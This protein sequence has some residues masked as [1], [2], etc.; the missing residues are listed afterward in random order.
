MDEAALLSILTEHQVLTALHT[1]ESVTV[2][3][4]VVDGLR[5][6][7]EQGELENAVRDYIA[8]NPWL[9]DPK[10]DTYKVERAMKK[11]VDPEATK[12]F[13]SEMLD[14]RLD[15][16]LASGPQLLVLEFMKP[17]LKL[18]G[19]HLSRFE[20]YV[21]GLRNSVESATGS[22]FRQVAG[23]IVADRIEEDPA[24]TAKLRD[25]AGDQKFALTWQLL[26]ERS[27]KHWA[28]FFEALVERTPDDPR[29]A[30]LR[31]AAEAHSEAEIAHSRSADAGAPK[32]HA[33]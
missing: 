19:D 25:M 3:K 22:E 10:W 6:R 4:Q 5:E 31:A 18:D 20:L 17:G 27:G 26:L 29:I 15:L 14:K 7:I 21:N 12:R 11:V 32:A 16:V 2:K 13:S 23:T 8:E 9:I 30:E 24:I 33:A 1:L 28:E